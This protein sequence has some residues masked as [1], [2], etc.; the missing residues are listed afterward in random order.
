M[1]QSPY[2][3]HLRASHNFPNCHQLPHCILL[4]LI[5]G[6]KSRLFQ[7][8]SFWEKPEVTGH[9]IWAVAGLSHLGDLMFLK[10]TLHET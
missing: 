8:F 9:Q 6:L 1:P 2:S 3:R 5:N 7:S 4:N 10:K